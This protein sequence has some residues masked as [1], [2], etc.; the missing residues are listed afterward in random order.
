LLLGGGFF[1]WR[2]SGGSISASAT[3]ND[4]IKV[5]EK[6][7]IR[8]VND[9]GRIELEGKKEL[10]VVEI[11]ARRYALGSDPSEAKGNASNVPINISREGSTFT[12]ET[13]GD[14]DTGTLTV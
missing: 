3:Y 14:E 2:S 8:L 11:E 13:G 5:G 1:L 7:T 4:S 10:N 12:I 9:R 6:P